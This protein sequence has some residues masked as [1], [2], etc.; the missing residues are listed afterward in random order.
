MLLAVLN[1][2]FDDSDDCVVVACTFCLVDVAE[3]LKD[4]TELPVDF[5]DIVVAPVDCPEDGGVLDVSVDMMN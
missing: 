3:P 4:V 2:V 5:T 1:N